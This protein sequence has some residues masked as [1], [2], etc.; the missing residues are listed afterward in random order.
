MTY[1]VGARE[2]A[3][4]EEQGLAER[5]CKR[6]RKTVAEIESGSMAA[7]AKM[8]VCMARK[9]GLVPIDR[10]EIDFGPGQHE[11]EIADGLRTVACVEDDRALDK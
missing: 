7:L 9:V 6:I 8:P 11:I 10:R 3:A 2:I 5:L 4:L 1:D